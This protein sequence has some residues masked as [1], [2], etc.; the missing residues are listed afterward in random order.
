MDNKIFLTQLSG[1]FTRDEFACK[2]CG[3]NKTK[4]ELI[5]KLQRL[6]DF[7]NLPIY[8]ESGYRCKKHNSN[9]G[10]VVNSQ[11]LLGKAADIMVKKNNKWMSGRQIYR[12]V[13]K[14]KLF[15]NH[16][17]GIYRYFVHLDIRGKH[18][19]WHVN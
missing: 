17:V 18:A 11:H 19:R 6:R 16:G 10:G 7:I 3:K 1:N 2:C 14:S 13:R 4:K 8:I 15:R 5:T 9:V 12:L